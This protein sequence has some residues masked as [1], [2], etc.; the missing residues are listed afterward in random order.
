MTLIALVN[1]A[2]L[3]QTDWIGKNLKKTF[4]SPKPVANIL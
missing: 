4:L 3:T 2:K 1:T